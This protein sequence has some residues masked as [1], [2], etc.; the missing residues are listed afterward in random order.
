M[1]D[2][3]Y[4][5]EY[6]M[7]DQ[8]VQDFYTQ[9]PSYLQDEFSELMKLNSNS[10]FRG[11][12]GP[13]YLCL[14]DNKVIGLSPYFGVQEIR[15]E[16]EVTANSTETVDNWHFLF[17]DEGTGKF[18]NS[19]LHKNE[20]IV[21]ESS[22]ACI[23][24]ED[25]STASICPKSSI[26]DK[27]TAIITTENSA[28]I[29]MFE[30]GKELFNEAWVV[31]ENGLAEEAREKFV[32]AFEIFVQLSQIDREN[33]EYEKLVVVSSLKIEGNKLLNEAVKLQKEA[34]ATN[35]KHLFQ[36]ARNKFQEASEKFM[37]GYEASGHDLKFKECSEF[38]E[39]SVKNINLAIRKL[40]LNT[41]IED[42]SFKRFDDF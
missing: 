8:T 26:D 2:I 35:M 16:I 39:T 21:S 17:F 29:N 28:P 24:R 15:I 41:E 25:L 42:Q 6:N 20:N 7:K 27:K 34:N 40:Q 23:F 37:K 9:L 22:L 10:V 13:G 31:E 33:F 5:S 36:E 11:Y 14:N 1:K 4:F 38:I 19:S 18:L 3:E 30:T 32:K 12:Q